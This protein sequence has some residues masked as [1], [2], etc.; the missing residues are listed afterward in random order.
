MTCRVCHSP[1]QLLFTARVLDKYEV[2]YH[3]CPTCRLVQ[4]ED[5]Y[6]LPEAYEKSIN[7]TDTGL[8]SRN[9]AIACS[10][11]LTEASASF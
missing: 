1:T 3:E 5:P 7:T 6:W 11:P 2:G 8:V 10:A 4:T 9:L